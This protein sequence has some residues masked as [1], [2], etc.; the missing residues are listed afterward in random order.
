MRNVLA[1]VPEVAGP[2]VTAI[3][4]TVLVPRGKHEL[5]RAQFDE[6]VT[7]LTHSHPAVTDTLDD[8]REDLLASAHDEWD[9]TDR[10]YFSENSTKLLHQTTTSIE[11][12]TID[13]LPAAWTQHTDPHGV[14]KIHHSAG[15]HLVKLRRTST[16]SPSSPSTDAWRT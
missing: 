7:M 4:R 15:R 11:E 13:E 6:V 9:A 12:A 10:H 16:T 3:I 5:V 8:A 1:K 2:T 14:E